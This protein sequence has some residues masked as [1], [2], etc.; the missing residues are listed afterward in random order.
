M[1]K[2]FAGL[3]GVL[4]LLLGL[5]GFFTHE[6]FGMIHF[7]LLHNIIH[8]GIG[9]AGIWAMRSEDTAIK[10][11]KTV[12]L[13]Y[14]VLGILGMVLPDMLGLMHMENA[15]NV[16]HLVVGVIGLYLGFTAQTIQTVKLKSKMN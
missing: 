10:F 7:D 9:A 8:L 12:G 4:F 15:E 2:P 16:L 5:T 1:V 11:A 13:L 14:V 3:V 6:L